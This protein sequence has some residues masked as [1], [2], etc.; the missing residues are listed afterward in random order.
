MSLHYL[1]KREP[2]NCVF[3][4]R[5]R[6]MSSPGECGWLRACGKARG[7]HFEHLQLTGSVQW[8]TVYLLCDKQSI[9]FTAKTRRKK[10]AA[11]ADLGTDAF[12]SFPCA[13]FPT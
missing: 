6:H 3:S 2:G 5:H 9:M 7:R 12:S 4:V 1:G 10:T 8:D 11:V 13:T